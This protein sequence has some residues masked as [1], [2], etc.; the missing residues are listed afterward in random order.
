M[1][2]NNHTDKD[3]ETK[4]PH[5]SHL[6]FKLQEKIEEF[7][8]TKATQKR[9][10]E[11]KEKLDTART[12]YLEKSVRV[13]ILKDFVISH[14]QNPTN[15]RSSRENSL[16]AQLRDNLTLAEVSCMLQLG[17]V[18]Q[19]QVTTLGIDPAKVKTK[20]S[21]D[22]GHELLPMLEDFTFLKCLRLLS[23][24]EPEVETDRPRVTQHSRVLRLADKVA[25]LV[26]SK[27]LNTQEIAGCKEVKR[28][29]LIKQAEVLENIAN[30]INILVENYACG[31][32]AEINSDNLRNY[33]VKVESFMAK[34][35][36]MILE[37][38]METY[39]ATKVQALRK[40]R[41]KMNTQTHSLES[42][43]SQT[44][45]MLEQYLKCGPELDDI[46]SSFVKLKK[47]LDCRKWAIKELKK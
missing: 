47:E 30:S 19:K 40:I 21:P 14:E 34:I 26:T 39:T 9:V 35:Q 27:E 38:K 24:L 12:R 6:L 25:D 5:F 3:L 20:S 7:G 43:I 31:S 18:K 32:F 13:Q 44:R 11:S 8:Q 36:K 33:S 37:V 29:D 42:E 22:L 1:I 17:N 16:V 2:M 23:I 15:S 45:T 4:C 28:K 10:T 41:N 46:V